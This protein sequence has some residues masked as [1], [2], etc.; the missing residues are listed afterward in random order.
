MTTEYSQHPHNPY[1]LV[2]VQAMGFKGLWVAGGGKE[3]STHK[4]HGHLRNI[5]IFCYN[6]S[7]QLEG[8]QSMPSGQVII[9]AFLSS[10][11]SFMIEQ[12]LICRGGA[13]WA[14]SGAFGDQ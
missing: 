6:K 1:P 11:V 14:D 7:T 13:L 5:C 4:S 9:D 8:K 10:S 12:R 3:I 2:T